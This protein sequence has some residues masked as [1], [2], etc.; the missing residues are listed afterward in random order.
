M[1][2]LIRP[3]LDVQGAVVPAART[4]RVAPPDTTSAEAAYLRQ[5][6]QGRGEVVVV[7]F[8]GGEL[9]GRLVGYDRECLAVQ[10]DEQP[11][12]LVRKSQVK[13]FWATKAAREAGA[14]EGR[15]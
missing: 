12:V 4:R 10:P 9:R 5:A 13:Y 1:R 14:R 8:G 2:K 3:S 7:L 6:L 15:T 11:P